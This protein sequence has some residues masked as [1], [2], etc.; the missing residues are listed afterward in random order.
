MNECETTELILNRWN[1]IDDQL[2]ASEFMKLAYEMRKHL[3][4]HTPI[5][6]VKKWLPH[7]GTNAENRFLFHETKANS[8]FI[9]CDDLVFASFL[10]FHFSKF[11]GVE[12]NQVRY[13]RYL[14]WL[15]EASNTIVTEFHWASKSVFLDKLNKDVKKDMVYTLDDQFVASSRD[16]SLPVYFPMPKRT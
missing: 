13:E 10:N 4:G 8:S 11:D 5:R 1:E 9:A 6:E 15:I 12:D 7:I 16:I 3:T 14:R 2:E